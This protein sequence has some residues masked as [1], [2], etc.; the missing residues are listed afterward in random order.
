M[1]ISRASACAGSS[2]VPRRVL[3]VTL[4]MIQPQPQPQ[5]QLQPGRPVN[6]GSEVWVCQR[7]GFRAAGRAGTGN[8]PELEHGGQVIS[9]GPMLAELA[10]LDAE[11]VA[12]S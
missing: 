8:E 7:S 1:S 5:P 4:W 9:G 2:S 10:V 12:L 6:A 11:P 3:D